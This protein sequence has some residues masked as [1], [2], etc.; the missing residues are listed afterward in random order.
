[1]QRKK[2]FIQQKFFEN[3]PS[4]P[5]S[6]LSLSDRFLFQK[7]GTG[8]QEQVSHFSL[9]DAFLQQL[10]EHPETIALIDAELRLT[11]L[12]LNQAAEKLA[13]LLQTLGVKQGD[14]VGL[15]LRRSA[16]MVIAQ[17]AC[18]KVGA[19]YVP[20]DIRVAPSGQLDYVCK[21]ADIRVVLT[22]NEYVGQLEYLDAKIQAVD[23]WLDNNE[24]SKPLFSP[25]KI[26]RD[27]TAFILFT[28]GTTGKPNGVQVSHK[29]VCNVVLTAPGNLGISRG[30][31][32]SQI[33][34]IA[35]DMAAWEIWACLCNGG[36]L[37]IRSHSI[38]E[39]V[40][41]AEVIIAT[42]SILAN[43]NPENCP[44]VQTAI[45]AGEP[46][47]ECLALKWSTHCE[48]YNACGPTE[49]TIVN[50]AICYRAN[51][52]LSIGVP[53]ANNR[54]YIL[55]ENLQPSPMGEV[56]MMWA[57]GDGVTK[58]YINNEILNQERYRLDPFTKDGRM[59]FR[60]G[61]L[62]RW[63]A[64]GELEHF[65]RADDQVK[66]RGFRVE[67]DSV[68]R[69]IEQV[70]DVERAL[71][72]K[73]DNENLVAFFLGEESSR[74]LIES[75][76]RGQLPYYCIPSYIGCLDSFPQTDRGKIDK[77][78]LMGVAK[79]AFLTEQQEVVV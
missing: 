61:D 44:R 62:G 79:E 75:H 4:D 46:C 37:T 29:N 45:V 43:I 68:A 32:V 67:L 16:S 25:I 18:F 10:K 13:G 47:P 65:G 21:C 19:A 5:L 72:L 6:T 63:N 26:N 1:M 9:Y 50:T 36:S 59:M 78:K 11:Y 60:T 27:D 54:V 35:F 76:V 57:G 14:A 55:D 3:L 31:A 38:A 53:T 52:P 33:L 7:Y 66:V 56:G 58:G 20:Q 70:L 41:N 2:T 24:E 8:A 42:P 30:T 15:F 73:Y 22:L 77:R 69:V 40:Q 17:L 71:V 28:S 74:E 12:A 34:S 49:T 64:Y 48:F 23:T 39:S 51:K